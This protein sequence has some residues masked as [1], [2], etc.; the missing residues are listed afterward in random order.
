MRAPRTSSFHGEGMNLVATTT[1][2]ARPGSAAS[3]EPM[4]RSL[5]PPPYTSAVSNRVTPASMEASQ[6]SRMVSRVRS[7]S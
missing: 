7:V 3:S 6:A 2:A 4:I 5:S 1:V